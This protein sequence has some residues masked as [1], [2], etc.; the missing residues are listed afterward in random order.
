MTAS[1]AEGHHTEQ[2]DQQDQQGAATN[3]DGDEVDIARL[4]VGSFQG[5]AQQRHG[6]TISVNSVEDQPN[7]G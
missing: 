4:V 6:P 2:C 7:P 5:D 3:Q 1:L